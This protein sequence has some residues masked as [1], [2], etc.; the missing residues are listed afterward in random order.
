[1]TMFHVL[2]DQAHSVPD[3]IM[4]IFEGRSW[5]Y[6]QFFDKVVNVSNWLRKDLGVQKE[7]IVALD[8]ARQ[9]RLYYALVCAR[10]RR[11]PSRFCK[12]QPDWEELAP[13][14]TSKLR[15]SIDDQKPDH[16]MISL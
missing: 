6:K 16:S 9:R 8:A 10:G 7:E 2:E 14:F 5:T 11:S 12:Q 13:L 1:M 4:L 3:N 15:M